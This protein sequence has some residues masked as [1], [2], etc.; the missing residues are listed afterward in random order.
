MTS[1]KSNHDAPLSLP[2]IGGVLNP[3]ATR[4]VERW[5]VL[6]HSDTVKAWIAAGVIE[7]I[8]D[9]AP[10][11]VVPAD[12]VVD[13]PVPNRLAKLKETEASE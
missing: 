5:S 9:E 1:L 8:A 2:I 6:Q 11:A 7:V 3:G 4:A 13:A 12:P 10:S